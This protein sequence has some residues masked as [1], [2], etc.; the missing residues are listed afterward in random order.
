MLASKK[1]RKRGPRSPSYDKLL[2]EYLEFLQN[3]QGLAKATVHI[4]K[5]YVAPFLAALKITTPENAR[6]L[7]PSRIHDYVIKTAKPMNRASRKHLVSSLRSF[8]RFSHI[9]GFHKRNLVEA[10]PV[11]TTPK[12]DRVPRAIPWESV[13]RLLRAPDRRTRAGRRDYAILQLVATY[14]VRIGQVTTLKLNDINWREGIIS[15]SS[16]KGGMPLCFPLQPDVASALLAY[17]RTRGKTPFPEV[18]LTVRG[19]PRPLGENNHLNSSMADYYRRAGIHS[20][21][22]GSHAIRHAFATRL[23]EQEVSI[24]TI[25]DLL[26]HRC[27]DTTFIYT[28]VDLKHLRLLAREWPEEAL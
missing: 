5:I 14:G 22:K 23:M 10:V 9:K 24:K 18:F 27:I 26:G 2:N 17:F 16:S 13:Q 11:I 8:L 15:F 19:N 4:R 7:S 3:H 21:T 20:S 25:A 12:L 28:K 1:T 6:I